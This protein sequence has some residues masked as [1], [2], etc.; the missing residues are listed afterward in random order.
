MKAKRKE[1]A[2]A[3]ERGRDHRAPSLSPAPSSDSTTSKA[4]STRGKTRQERR[5]W[6]YVRAPSPR[7]FFTP[8]VKGQLPGDRRPPPLPPVLPS[9]DV[10]VLAGT[11][12]VEGKNRPLAK[13]RPRRVLPKMMELEWSESEGASDEED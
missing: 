13:H 4:G 2:I 9:P 12:E 5:G 3:V 1:T 11:E 8:A 6:F 7:P 10:W